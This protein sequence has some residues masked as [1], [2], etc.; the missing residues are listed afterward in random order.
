MTR[1]FRLEKR[2]PAKVVIKSIGVHLLKGKG[3]SPFHEDI[4]H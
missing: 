1:P 4:T 3:D 2:M